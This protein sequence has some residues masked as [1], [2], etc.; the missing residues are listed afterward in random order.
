MKSDRAQSAEESVVHEHAQLRLI[1]DSVRET[2]LDRQAT[3]EVVAAMTIELSSHI[4]QHFD[5]EEQA[6][7][8]EEV[9]DVAPRLSDRA[10][11]LLQQHLELVDQLDLL[12]RHAESSAPIDSW[13]ARLNQMFDEFFHR[14]L[15]HE[16]AENALLLQAY[17][18][19]IGAED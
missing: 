19:D 5:H 9:I 8:F 10:E 6:G 17:N 14:F 11:A 2:F 15:A 1:L 3:P 13:W 12:Q 4:K 7:Y 18:E 16:Q